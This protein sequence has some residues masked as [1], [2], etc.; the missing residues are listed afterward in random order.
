MLKIYLDWNIITKLKFDK[1]ESRELLCAIEEYR[2]YFIFPYSM[3]HLHDL[4]SGNEY[5]EG[6]HIDLENLC[7][8]CETH[9]LEYY[10]DIDSAYPYQCTPKEYLEQKKDEFAVF[11]SGFSEESFANMLS[12]QGIDFSNFMDELS[13]VEVA[14]VEI[15]FLN[16]KV[17]N[18]RDGLETVFRLGEQYARDKSV[19]GKIFKYLKDTTPDC[20]FREIMSSNNDTIFQV[21]DS[22]TNQQVNKSF[23]EII[24]DFQTQKNDMYFFISL[25]LALN[26]SGFNSDKKK[27]ILNIY[28][29]AEHCY[30]AS[31][32]D[33]L[34]SEDENLRE[35]AS[36][37]YKLLGIRT[38]IMETKEFIR[39]METEAKQE[40]DLIN[41]W[42][43]I[44]PEYGKPT[45]E[46]GEQLFYKQ[47]P[48]RFFGFFNFCVETDNLYKNLKPFVLR[49]VLPP[50]GF[51]Y[52]TELERFFSLIDVLLTEE[53]RKAFR[54]QYKDVF[55]TRDKEK[56]MRA[57]FTI[58]LGD[59]L[60]QLR[61]DPDSVIPLP[62]MLLAR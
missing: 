51:V 34:V 11:S 46:E 37:M 5:C 6:Y 1:K 16:V 12:N 17:R 2:N 42:K 41:F 9:L 47:L 15:P 39:F 20:Q 24:K 14:P 48:I 22:I 57:S 62:M 10:G 30:Y 32:C 26:A 25:Y 21:L 4:R 56:I 29:D 33:F 31:K 27:S 52:F 43:N 35:K 53:G 55:M 28:T 49:L 23:V 8:I 18:A 60:M 61:A 3:A 38:T 59:C 7:T 19:S 50:N 44:A 13:K 45:R 54:E 58:D 40:Y 36:A